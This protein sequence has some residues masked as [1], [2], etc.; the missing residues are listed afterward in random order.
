ME[1]GRGNVNNIRVTDDVIKH[2]KTEYSIHAISEV[3]D[4]GNIN[5]CILVT[6]SRSVK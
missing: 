4:R 1:T 6:R 5:D 3:V 2:D